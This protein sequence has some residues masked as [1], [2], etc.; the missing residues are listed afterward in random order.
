MSLSVGIGGGLSCA[1]VIDDR[2]LFGHENK[3]L[4]NVITGTYPA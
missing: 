3:M 1:T 2:A 4:Q